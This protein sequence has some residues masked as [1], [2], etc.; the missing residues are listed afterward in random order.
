MTMITPSYL[1]E[2][3][4]YSS[5]HACRSTLEDPT[6]ATRRSER[7]SPGCCVIWHGRRRHAS[8]AQWSTPS[9][10]GETRS[11]GFA[12]IAL[13]ADPCL[14]CPNWSASTQG[15]CVCSRAVAAERAGN[16]GELGAPFAK[17]RM[18][19][20]SRHWR[21]KERN[22]CEST[23]VNPAGLTSKPMTEQ[24]ARTCFWRIGLPF[25]STLL[26]AIVD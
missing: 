9:I 12:D 25:T 19:I 20:G 3:I 8:S 15:A 6:W 21:S 23:T 7:R 18:A 4:E 22:T 11:S 5:L 10:V 2:T 26:L 1:G 13:R 14:R 16:S 17:P 24:G